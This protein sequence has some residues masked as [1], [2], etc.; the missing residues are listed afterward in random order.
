MQST[1]PRPPII[2]DRAGRAATRWA[3][4]IWSLVFYLSALGNVW[5]AWLAAR[6]DGQPIVVW[7]VLSWELSSATAA[8][9]LLPAVVWLCARW[10]LHAD[11]WV[12][13]LPA[14]VIVA[15][16]WWLLH[17]AGMVVLRLST[18]WPARITISVA[19]CSGSTSCPRICAPL[20]C[21][22]RYST[23]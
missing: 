23:R 3:V 21:W 6:R 10:P 4:V 2:H 7:Q 5:T 18:H 16:G 8:L 9:M 1:W 14:Y 20:R 15:L 22:W 12:R 17:V 19:G 13:R 11:V